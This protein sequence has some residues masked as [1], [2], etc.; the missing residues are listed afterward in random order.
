MAISP[1]LR[2]RWGWAAV[3]TAAVLAFL[4]AGD[5]RDG[6]PTHHPERALSL[7]WWVLVGVGADAIGRSRAR[8]LSASRPWPRQAF[9]VVIATA[10]LGWCATLP[11]R[12]TGVPGATAAERRDAQVAE[13]LALRAAH[14][15][16][17]DVTPCAFEHFAVLAAW[18]YPERAR[19]HPATHQPVTA[20][21]P[22]IDLATPPPPTRE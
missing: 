10:A 12:W 18:G 22:R 14:V 2:R 19:I 16:S 13:G 1:G 4:I 3:A 20:A 8:A 6:A 17:I 21:C 9:G 15:E 11:S 5:V 7:A